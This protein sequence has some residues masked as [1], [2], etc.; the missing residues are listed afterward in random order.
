MNMDLLNAL[1]TEMTSKESVAALAKN[2]KVSQ[3]KASS[4]VTEALPVLLQGLTNNSSTQSGASSL[5]HALTQHT[6]TDSLASQIAGADTQDGSAII[7]HIL[8]DNSASVMG[9]LAAK[10]GL[11]KGKIGTILAS[12]AP[13]LLS[14]LSGITNASQNQN[15]S[16]GL[17]LSGLGSLFGSL[18]GGGNSGG[19]ILSLTPSQPQ[20][21]PQQQASSGLDLGG[22][23]GSLLGGL[24]GSQQ[25]AQ[26]QQS[27]GFDGSALLSNLL[28]F[29]K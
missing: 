14:G 12:L 16:G 29:M 23:V 25:Q 8:G 6:S 22:L 2:A 27:S 5:L 24:G 19:S 3:K 20:Q 10:T 1:T 15:T 21:Q 13:A 11:T 4:V 18:L 28:G 26:P 17:D 9:D 7:G